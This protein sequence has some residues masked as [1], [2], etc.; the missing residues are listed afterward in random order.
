MLLRL[1]LVDLS[2]NCMQYI[3]VDDHLPVFD[4]CTLN[5]Q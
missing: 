2:L 5:C 1:Q 4:D 3:E